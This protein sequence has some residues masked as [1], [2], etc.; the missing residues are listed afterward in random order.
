MQISIIH[1]CDILIIVLQK[2]QTTRSTTLTMCSKQQIQSTSQ[3]P[4]KLKSIVALSTNEALAL[5]T[6]AKVPNFEGRGS[7]PTICNCDVWVFIPPCANA[8]CG[9]C[10]IL[11]ELVRLLSSSLSAMHCIG[12]I[13]HCSWSDIYFYL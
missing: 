8:L 11:S 2:S 1:I 5:L 10:L 3:H 12:Q 6:K 9:F 13:L 7:S 4:Q